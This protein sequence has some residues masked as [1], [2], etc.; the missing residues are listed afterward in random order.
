MKAKIRILALLLYCSAAGWAQ[1][2]SLSDE[3]RLNH[4]QLEILIG[5]NGS[6][7]VLLSEELLEELDMASEHAGAYNLNSLTYDQ[8]RTGLRLSDYQYYQ[9][10]LY[11]EEH[12]ALASIYEL[13][14]IEGFGAKERERLAS[15]VYARFVSR[16]AFHWRD[17]I[18]KGRSTLLLR[19]QTVLERQAGYDTSRS[20]HY[21]G[22]P[23][24]V[25]FRYTYSVP[26]RLSIKL[27]G[28]KDPGEEFFKGK[29]PYG[30]DFYAGSIAFT[31]TGILQSAVLG[32]YRLNF[33]Q[34][35]A[36]GSSI[37]SGKGSPPE[38]LRRFSSGI[39]SVAP[40]NEGDFLRGGAVTIGKTTCAGTLFLGRKFGSSTNAYG[41]DIEYRGVL[42]KVGVRVL[43]FSDA[44]TSLTTL[45]KRFT[46]FC[47]PTR[48]LA[49]LDHHVI[50][51]RILST[52]EVSVNE[53]GK[54]AILQTLFLPLT[55]TDKIALLFRH[56]SP[57]YASDIGKGFRASSSGVGESGV[58]I[59]SQHI[60]TRKLE[61][62]LYGDYYRLHTPSYQT[63]APVTGFD[64]GSTLTYTLSR[65]NK[66]TLNYTFRNKPENSKERE[67]YNILHEHQRHK[68]RLQLTAKPFE[69][70]Q[71]RT[72]IDWLTNYYKN[73]QKQ[74]HGILLFQ[75]LAVQVP[76]PALSFHIRL[77]YFNTDR[78]DERL[79][80]YEDDLYYAFTIGSYYYQGVR[81]YI[82]MRYKYR[83][84]SIWLRFSQTHYLDR[85]TISSG[86][87]QIDKPHKSEIKVQCVCSF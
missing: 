18:K 23:L 78:Y 80:A 41:I 14:I 5:E 34:G 47:T 19:A 44:D 28:E 25:C 43:G 30:F 24:H 52:G 29:Q 87:T 48:M 62:H 76:R 7:E 79:Y 53:S 33:G 16:D 66:L 2:D 26:N 39:R 38:G 11:I 70:I 57:G 27:S 3:I 81:G 73:E 64:F 58:Y 17:L 72:E 50:L 32:D 22:S 77:A 40:T 56:Y 63:D 86:L 1:S 61:A 4:N 10:Q 51:R 85:T 21:S 45:A 31:K 12:G 67:R 59:T 9:L 42:F 15:S 6:E 8:A 74:Y 65:Q 82:V 20:N 13:D 71:L 46:A 60:L 83:W 36:M 68:L 69:A 84:L 54:I 55:P 49:A 35:L 37:L 75:D